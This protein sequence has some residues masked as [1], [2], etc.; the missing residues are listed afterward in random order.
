MYNWNSSPTV[1]NCTFTNNPNGAMYNSESSPTITNCTFTGNT[2]D[3]G[4]GEEIYNDSVSTAKIMYCDIQGGINGSRCAGN[5]S[6]DD[7]GNINNDSTFVRNPDPGLNG[8]DGVDD[9]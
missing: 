8:W 1:T 3:A 9:N 2:A 6:S 7:G 4:T 5:P